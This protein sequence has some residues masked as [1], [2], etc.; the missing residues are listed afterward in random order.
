MQQITELPLDSITPYEHNPRNNA[1]AVD[2][3][4]RSI[5]A[6]GFNVP[7]VVDINHVIVTGHTRY[8]ASKRLGLA[9]VPCIIAA[10]LTEEQAKAYRLADN[11]VAELATW[12]D[13]LLRQEIEALNDM[14]VDLSDFGFEE[15]LEEDNPDDV[16]EHDVPETAEPITNPG[17]LFQL[18]RHRLL[19]GDATCPEDL[20]TLTRGVQLPLLLTEPPRN[21]EEV[22]RETPGEPDEDLRQFLQASFKAVDQVMQPG[23]TLYL[24]HED[25]EAPAVYRAATYPAWSIK[26][27]IVWVQNN[28]TLG[29]SDYQRQHVPCIYAVKD[30]APHYFAEH[31]NDSTVI[32]DRPDIRNLSKPELVMLC[33]DL[34]ESSPVETS[35]L[36]AD[37]PEEPDTMPVKLFARLIV[38]SSRKGD[39]ILDPFA[40][41]GTTAIAAEQLGRSAYLMEIDPKRCDKIIK[42]WED[43]TGKKARL[44]CHRS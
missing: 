8:E 13:E 20:K 33:R 11:K 43:A 25:S 3:V 37:K 16:L 36:R 9:T 39:G 23:A 7:I 1:E 18:G 31:R 4:A 22:R 41:S 15:D 19:C 28:R 29:G 32:E 30:G 10:H 44:L 21:L 34:L 24:W 40:G 14:G 2:A 17:D 42:R 12:N 26:Q 27:Q 35:V 6:F 38:N 5:Q